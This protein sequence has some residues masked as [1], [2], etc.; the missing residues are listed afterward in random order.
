MALFPATETAEAALH[1]YLWTGSQWMLGK[2]GRGGAGMVAEAKK[3][4][5]TQGVRFSILLLTRKRW[6]RWSREM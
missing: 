1:L 3:R 2:P 6:S 4:A 5:G